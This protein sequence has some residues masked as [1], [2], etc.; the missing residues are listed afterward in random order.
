MLFLCM[1]PCYNN[2]NNKEINQIFKGGHLMTLDLKEAMET[3]EQK[4]NYHVCNMVYDK[5]LYELY[6]EEGEVI[7]DN[8]SEAQV[9]DLSKLL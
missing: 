7:M 1:F 2:L 9:V 6:N 4:R 5:T 3:L 8:L